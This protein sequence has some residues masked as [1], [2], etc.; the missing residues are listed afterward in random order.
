[1]DKAMMVQSQIRQNAEEISQ[2]LSDLNKWEKTMKARGGK[3]NAARKSAPA[4]RRG[5]GT[6]KVAE[7][8]PADPQVVPLN[9]EKGASGGDA[10]DKAS[11]AARHTYDVGYKKWEKFDVDSALASDD[12]NEEPGKK[13][14]TAT[15]VQET[16]SAGSQSEVEIET[17]SNAAAAASALKLT[18]A[19]LVKRYS[20][21]DVLSPAASVVPRARGVANDKDGETAERERGNAEYAAGN[22][23]A[24]VKSYTKCLG[25]KVKSRIFF[26]WVFS[27]QYGFPLVFGNRHAD[28]HVSLV[29]V[30]RVVLS[31]GSYILWFFWL[32]ATC[33]YTHMHVSLVVVWRVV[34]PPGSYTL[35]ALAA[36]V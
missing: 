21:A 6:V 35:Y 36:W 20:K 2:Y 7:N 22:F 15:G 9:T 12:D 34:L 8:A 25:M 26:L 11:S 4:V 31:P 13:H 1:M 33:L 3:G 29:V 5:C 18:P 16:S 24:A 14:V 28:M 10:S 19:S 32:I 23:T 17:D 27:W 30:W